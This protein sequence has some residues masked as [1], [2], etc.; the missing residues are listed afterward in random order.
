M[1][2]EFG[3]LQ[4]DYQISTQLNGKPS[5]TKSTYAIYYCM[6]NWAF[7]PLKSIGGGGGYAWIYA[8]NDF[9]G[10]TDNENVW[11]FSI[12]SNFESNP[13]DIQIAYI[14]EW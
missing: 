4:G 3:F 10:L 11:K 14:H 1:L 5:W 9:S 12:G 2:N 13:T 6:G 7:G 8:I